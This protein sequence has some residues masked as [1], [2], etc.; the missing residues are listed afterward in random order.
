[1]ES[2]IDRAHDQRYG[3]RYEARLIVTPT[4]ALGAEA[5]RRLRAGEDF[6]DVARALSTDPSAIAGGRIPPVHPAD[7]SWPA[8]VR[9]ALESTTPGGL[10]PLIAVEGGYALLRMERAFAPAPSGLSAEREREIARRD[11]RL[12][13]ERLLMAGLAND[14]LGI[15]D[16]EI[17]DAALGRAWERTVPGSR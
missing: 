2:A 4:P 5:A 16:V 12:E 7:L 3:T 17:R 8:A 11:A 10:T 6:D 9:T 1:S 13:A 14:L 15:A